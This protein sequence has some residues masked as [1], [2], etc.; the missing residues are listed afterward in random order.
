MNNIPHFEPMD[1][2]L[3]KGTFLECQLDSL[4]GK[5]RIKSSIRQSKQG[6]THSKVSYL[7]IS[8]FLFISVID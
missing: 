4:N 3:I 2:I 1:I 8:C 6:I 7:E 5:A